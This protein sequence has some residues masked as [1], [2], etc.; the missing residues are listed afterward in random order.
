MQST[1]CDVDE[2]IKSPENPQGTARAHGGNLHQASKQYSIDIKKILDFSSNVNPLGPSSAAKR[3]AKRSLS[4]IGRYPDPEMADLRKAI[5]RYF[6]IKSEQVICGPGITGLLHLIPRV[7]RSRKVLVPMPSFTEYVFAAES[8]GSEVV[9]L[10][11]REQDGFRMDPVEISFAFKGVDLAFLCNPNDPTGQLVTKTEMIE[12]MQYAHDNNVRLVVDEAFMDYL[13]EES[14]VKEAVQAA[15][16]ICLRS[17]AKFFGMPGFRIG[18][19]VSDEVTI[20]S[21]RNGQEPWSV[22]IPAEHA[23]IAALGDWGHI[24]RTRRMIEKERDRLL[25]ELRLLPGVETLPGAANFILVKFVSADTHTIR[26]K[27]G[28]RSML[29][30]DCSSFPGLDSRYIRIA[31]RTRKENTRLIKALREM[32]IK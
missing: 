27:L 8:A 24:K 22:N 26:E 25:S 23:A 20:A 2:F 29:V 3:A 5:A 15:G 11:L 30:Q 13:A 4:F 17:F 16:I 19:A 31:V 18:Y 14:I 21:L 7:F 6:G 32:M 28:L 9:C 1:E 12:I 10:P